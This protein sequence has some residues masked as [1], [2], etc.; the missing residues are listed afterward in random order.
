MRLERKNA[1]FPLLV[2]AIILSAFIASF[3][4]KGYYTW[5]FNSVVYLPLL[6]GVVFTVCCLSALLLLARRQSRL[7]ELSPPKAV[8]ALSF[9]AV[10]GAFFAVIVASRPIFP[11]FYGDG[12]IHPYVYL[13]L[14]Y[15]LLRNVA[16]LIEPWL[17]GRPYYYFHP[18]DFT[19]PP[20]SLAFGLFYALI[21][22]LLVLKTGASFF[23]QL[24]GL[25]Y[26]AFIP[27]VV[28]F[29]G[30]W[31]SYSIFVAF[32]CASLGFAYIA[33][34][35]RSAVFAAAAL[36]ALLFAVWEKTLGAVLLLY[37]LGWLFFRGLERR[38]IKGKRLT[39]CSVVFVAGLLLA[40]LFFVAGRIPL[41]AA[42]RSFGAAFRASLAFDGLGAALYHPLNDFLPAVLPFAAFSLFL[43]F[44]RRARRRLARDFAALG[45]FWVSVA[46]T[47]VYYLI[48]LFNPIAV[49]GSSDLLVHAGTVGAILAVPVY[50][51]AGRVSRRPVPA[52]AVFCLFI[53]LPLLLLQ[54]RPAFLERLERI[55]RG[56]GYSH[57]AT[58]VEFAASRLLQGLSPE[59]KD[60]AGVFLLEDVRPEV[61]RRAFEPLQTYYRVLGKYGYARER[62]GEE[63]LREFL[64]H[65]PETF[66]FLLAV[67]PHRSGLLL[68][69]RLLSDTETIAEELLEKTGDETYRSVIRAAQLE[70]V[71]L[72]AASDREIAAVLVWLD[73]QRHPG[74]PRPPDGMKELGEKILDR[75]QA[76][77]GE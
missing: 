56:Q 1:W 65:R 7:E 52:L 21:A 33:L 6:S 54:S 25:L 5:S 31:D 2:G 29:T 41:S 66:S 36:A 51:A 74:T 72:F 49:R 77:L 17:L 73:Y 40:S 22:L 75:L 12:F 53:T 16:G 18:L 19:M 27:P 15:D 61:A 37:P 3:L 68:T 44:S 50:L 76:S 70:K 69:P 38:G 9:A 45:M 14:Q 71:R 39:L 47:A 30:H 13:R 11:H 55:L 58:T 34:E 26:F 46:L 64:L 57:S 67:K 62:S 35:K 43:A 23:Q 48:N 20:V 24:T 28:N 42:G 60:R 4:E 59:L 10:I 8:R 32:A 63:L